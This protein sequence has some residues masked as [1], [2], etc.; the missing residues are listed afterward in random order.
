M[1]IF[2][3]LEKLL[4]EKYSNSGFEFLGFYY[5]DNLETVK[6]K[7]NEFTDKLFKDY[8]PE[9]EVCFKNTR[10]EKEYSL[11]IEDPED[12]EISLFSNLKLIASKKLYLHRFDESYK[13]WK[14]FYNATSEIFSDVYSN[15]NTDFVNED[16][17]E[18]SA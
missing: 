7:E 11:A 1:E 13:A 18:R 16:V 9:I 8:N 2:K 6:D 17:E 5:I 12:D 14:D 10:D 4:Q 15:K 3:D